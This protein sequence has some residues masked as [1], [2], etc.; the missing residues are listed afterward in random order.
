MA[1]TNRKSFNLYLNY[2]EKNFPGIKLKVASALNTN[3]LGSLNENDF[4]FVGPPVPASYGE[5][6]SWYDKAFDFIGKALPA[7]LTY[8]I[9]KETADIQ[10]ERAKQGLPPIDMSRYGAAPV[11]VRHQVDPASFTQAIDP[12]TKQMLWIGGLG[13]LGLLLWPRLSGN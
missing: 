12:Q 4:D 1:K 5:E 13:I 6:Q 8:D 7:Y 9:Q 11:T 10:M 3:G 2:L